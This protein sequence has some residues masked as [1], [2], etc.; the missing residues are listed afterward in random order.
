MR[1]SQD[2]GVASVTRLAVTCYIPLWE[3]VTKQDQ[4]SSVLLMRGDPHADAGRLI[5]GG[6]S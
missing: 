3:G 5:S 1:D 2:P 4:T 6:L